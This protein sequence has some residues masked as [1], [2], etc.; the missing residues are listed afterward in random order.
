MTREQCLE[1]RQAFLVEHYRPGRD[2]PQLSSSIARIR[3]IVAEMK[4]AGEPVRC[5]S[6]TIVPNDESFFCLIEAASDE[7]VSDVYRRADVPFERISAAIC[8]LD[9]GE[10]S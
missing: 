4:R 9:E 7:V 5:L 3:Q 6:A 1:P 8:V 10:S 2:V